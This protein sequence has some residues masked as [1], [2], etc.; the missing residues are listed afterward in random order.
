MTYDIRKI[1]IYI[2]TIHSRY[3]IDT[4]GVVYTSLGSTTTRVLINGE[5]YNINGFRKANVSSLNSSS[6]MLMPIPFA[7]NYFLLYNGD[8]LKRLSTRLRVETQ[9]VD[10][11]LTTCGAE[12]ND[13]RWKIARLMGYV[14][15]GI[16]TSDEEIHH[17]DRDRTNNRLSNL[18]ALTKEEH[19]GKNNFSK[20]HKKNTYVSTIPFVGK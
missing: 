9:E 10:V 7:K 8:I 17:I 12:R 16:R 19:R 1:N 14:F 15:L 20:L 3:Y 11:C 2:P 4:N 6:K 13:K 5:R 18:Q